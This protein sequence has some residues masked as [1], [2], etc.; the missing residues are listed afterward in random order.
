MVGGKSK[1]AAKPA[2]STPMKAMKGMKSKDVKSAMKA[3]RRAVP[4]KSQRP[5]F[6]GS[7]DDVA[8]I[9]AEF[10]KVPE[11]LRYSEALDAP[12][13]KDRIKEVGPM[14]R[15]IHEKTMMNLAFSQT[16]AE[17]IFVKVRELA[18]AK[19]QRRMTPS[20]AK[21]W[22]VA[23]ARQFRAMARH[24]SC[25]KVKKYTWVMELLDLGEHADGEGAETAE[26]EDCEEEEAEEEEE[27]VAKQP[28]AKAKQKASKVEKP[29]LEEE[30]NLAPD[31][32]SGKVEESKQYTYGYD[33]ELQN[34]WRLSS[35][36]GSKN[37][38]AV[39]LLPE[40][41]ATD[42][43]HPVATF[44]DGHE[45]GIK[46]VTMQEL[47][48]AAL[49]KKN[50]SPLLIIFQMTEN[51]TEQQVCQI[52]VRHFGD[53]ASEVGWEKCQHWFEAS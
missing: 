31:R 48:R 47:K 41:G 34:A 36:P 52:H 27:K 13:N 12:V 1:A 37:E 2:A 7:T 22:A 4:M 46:T 35:K 38:W 18:E 23:Q 40:I 9:I 29:K 24:I 25:A 53:P 42:A 17:G 28:K 51:G 11:V 19:W 30:P 33:T 5:R 20:E 50:R 3:K 44:K 8:K 45:E 15:A 49:L 21:D 10:A 26:A 14:W 6:K 43:S 32:K 39:S 16:Q